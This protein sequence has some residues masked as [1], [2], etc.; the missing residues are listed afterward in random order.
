VRVVV[1]DVVAE[2]SK[3]AKTE[4]NENT[5]LLKGSGYH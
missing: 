2:R 3:E 5:I 1:D 4:K